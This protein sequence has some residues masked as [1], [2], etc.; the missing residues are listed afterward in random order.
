MTPV[1]KCFIS[2]SKSYAIA[3]AW[4]GCLTLWVNDTSFNGLDWD[5]RLLHWKTF[6]SRMLLLQTN[7]P[8]KWA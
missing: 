7:P 8:K 5:I 2:G 3:K 4:A 6:P 1:Q